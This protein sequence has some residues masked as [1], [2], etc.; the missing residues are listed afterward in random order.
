MTQYLT[1]VLMMFVHCFGRERERKDHSKAHLSPAV[2]PGNRLEAHLRTLQSVCSE[3]SP[4]VGAL[5][6]RRA[7]TRRASEIRGCVKRRS[8]ICSRAS[9][10]SPPLRH[11]PPSAGKAGAAAA[12]VRRPQLHQQV[13]Q[14]ILMQ[15]RLIC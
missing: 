12:H 13:K 8:L 10:S 5:A 6:D 4:P 9:P 15:S 7:P 11:R 2:P 1:Y 3:N 14:H